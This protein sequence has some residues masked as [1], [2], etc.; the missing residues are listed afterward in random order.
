[1]KGAQRAAAK[2]QPITPP[3]AKKNMA[4]EVLR[5]PFQLMK[6]A[7]PSMVM[8]MAKLEGRKAV[9]EWKLPGLVTSATMKKRPI[10]GFRA[11]HTALHISVWLRAQTRARA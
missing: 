8:Y 11:K 9:L 2:G 7:A 4:L 10:L 6:A 5:P 1:M 3:M